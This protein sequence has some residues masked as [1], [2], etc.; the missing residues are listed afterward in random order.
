MR[1]GG[2]DTKVSGI[3]DNAVAQSLFFFGVET[4]VLTPRMEQDLESFQNDH[5]EEA[6]VPT[7]SWYL[8][9]PASDGGTTAS[10]W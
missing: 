5:Q 3:F 6:V 1:G 7:Y 2:A 9:I 10:S 8:G 4:W